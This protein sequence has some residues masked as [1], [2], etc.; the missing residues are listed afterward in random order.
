MPMAM[1]T[2]TMMAGGNGKTTTAAAE[3]S[4]TKLPWG[5]PRRCLGGNCT[6]T[7]IVATTMAVVTVTAAATTTVTAADDDVNNIEEDNKEDDNINDNEGEDD[8]RPGDD[9]FYRC[10][11]N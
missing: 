7:A 6:M 11:K 4:L 2:A 10:A 1:E 9:G 8:Q 3:G 5:T